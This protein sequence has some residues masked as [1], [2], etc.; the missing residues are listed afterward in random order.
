MGAC[1]GVFSCDEEARCMR[2]L[3][4]IPNLTMGGAE[5]VISELANAWSMDESLSIDVVLLAEGEMFYSLSSGVKIHRLGFRVG[6]SRFRRAF[7]IFKLALRFRKVATELSPDFVLSFMNKYNIFVLSSLFGTGTKVVV[8]ERDSPT[9]VLPKFTGLLRKFTYKFADGII[10]QTRA[11]ADFI[12][13]NV[14]HSRVTVIYNPVKKIDMDHGVCREKII[15]NIGRLVSKKGQRY[16]LEAFAR[17]HKE[18]PEWTLVIVGDGPL[19]GELEHL[20]NELGLQNKIAFPGAIKVVDDWLNRASIFAFPSLLEGFPNALAE[21]MA[22]GLAVVSFNCDTGPSDLIVDGKNGYLVDV[23][24]VS[25]LASRLEALMDDGDLRQRMSSEARKVASTLDVGIV[26]E[27]YLKFCIQ[28]A[29][30]S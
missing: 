29:L 7:G 24:D 20:S 4:A 11:S 13:K 15:L 5:R 18:Y 1:N 17:I 22:G 2:I 14:G 30:N 8:S 28:S 9:E 26:S 23:F 25:S 19:R 6:Q 3:I 21:A 12:E 27:K 16:L 10:C